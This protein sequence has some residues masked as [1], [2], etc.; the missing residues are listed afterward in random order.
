[1]KMKLS[2]FYSEDGETTIYICA[3]DIGGFSLEIYKKGEYNGYFLITGK[4]LYEVEDIVE[5]YLRNPETLKDY[6]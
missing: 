3:V 1:M 4:Q 2:E 5:D 6:V